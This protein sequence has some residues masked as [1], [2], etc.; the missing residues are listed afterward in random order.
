MKKIKLFCKMLSMIFA[1]F[2]MCFCDAPNGYICAMD[3]KSV[4]E[5]LSND[6]IFLKNGEEFWLFDQERIK[7]ENAW[8]AFVR[9]MSKNFG[10]SYTVNIS[11]EKDPQVL[12]SINFLFLSLYFYQKNF[13]R[14]VD[15]EDA[16]QATQML[17]LMFR[18]FNE[19]A[20]DKAILQGLS[21]VNADFNRLKQI[22]A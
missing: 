10:D 18:D 13:E 6:S 19:Q 8:D 9:M 16:E 1:I 17:H 4:V 7:V 21:E 22:L 15:M 12:D 2:M 14:M 5:Q 3:C 20:R 11:A